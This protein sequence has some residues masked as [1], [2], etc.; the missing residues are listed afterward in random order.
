MLDLRIMA[1]YNKKNN[2][3]KIHC[4]KKD[5]VLLTIITDEFVP[6]AIIY[7]NYIALYNKINADLIYWNT[8]YDN[9]IDLLKKYKK[10]EIIQ[11]N[12]IS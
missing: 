1:K 12:E 8:E 6:V 9:F 5:M 11:L 3:N 4:S 2:V 10:Y 7:E